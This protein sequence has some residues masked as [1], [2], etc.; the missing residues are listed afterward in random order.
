MFDVMRHVTCV[1]PV[2]GSVFDVVRHV[3]VCV[4]SV[5][6]SVFDAM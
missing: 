1:R 6:G 4:R 3:I 5:G 2:G